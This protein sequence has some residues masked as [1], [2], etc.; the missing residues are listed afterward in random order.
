MKDRDRDVVYGLPMCSYL[1]SGNGVRARQL[2]SK[3]MSW[4]AA[5]N[6]RAHLESLGKEALRVFSRGKQWLTV[7][8]AHQVL[9]E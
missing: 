3:A 1:P 5:R 4:Q 7:Y 2:S 8:R 6:V 9:S